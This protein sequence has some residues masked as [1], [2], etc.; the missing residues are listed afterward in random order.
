[1]KTGS[2][3]VLIIAS[4]AIILAVQQGVE[5]NNNIHITKTHSDKQDFLNNHAIL[6]RGHADFALHSRFG[7]SMG[8]FSLESNPI[9]F[10]H[11]FI[12]IKDLD[13]IK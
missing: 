6:Y 4:L 10:D 11:S 3:L 12:I 7:T 8:D 5:A 13:H 1:M 2:K 9:S